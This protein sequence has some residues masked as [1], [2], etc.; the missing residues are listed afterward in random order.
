MFSALLPVNKYVITYELAHGRPYSAFEELLLKQIHE[1][2]PDGG[3]G[4]NQLRATFK[5]HNRLITEGLVTLIQEGWV[6]IVQHE[7]EM[8]YLV[9]EAGKITVE[10]GRRPENRHVRT[11]YATIARERL[12]GQLARANDLAL[13]TNREVQ[14]ATRRSVWSQ[15]LKPS[16]TRTAINGGEA[17]RLLYRSSE[18]QEWV[19]W[20]DSVVRVSQDAHYLPV[21]VDIS[22]SQ[23]I[24]LPD[25]WQ[26]LSPL[27]VAQVAER[28]VDDEEATRFHRELQELLRNRTARRASARQESEERP[29]E[30]GARRWERAEPFVAVSGPEV[31]VGATAMAG[32][33][34]ALEALNA[35]IGNVLIV[36]A[37]LTASRAKTAR[38]LLIGL[39]GRG[40]N[41]DF[42]WSAANAAEQD[43]EILSVLG[44]TRSNRPSGANVAAA[45]IMYNRT[46]CQATA[47]LML[48]ETLEGPVAVTGDVLLDELED[49]DGARL[50]PAARFAE[51]AALASLARLCAGWWEEL[52]ANEGALPAHRWKHL[53]ERWAGQAAASNVEDEQTDGVPLTA[54]D[55][56]IGPQRDAAQAEL[57]DSRSVTELMVSSKR[58]VAVGG[59]RMLVEVVEAGALGLSYCVTTSPVTQ[60]TD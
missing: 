6:A 33:R 38:D 4:L 34:L 25:R 14:N 60:K 47:D 18:N 26:H 12:T 49:S 32:S 11:A 16:I 56:F 48:V 57:R 35:A 10:S 45:T 29:G 46:P 42:L 15:A 52:P 23:V 22:R 50:S 31:A 17:E 2:T 20:I 27:I 37:G 24:G 44:A 8:R 43:K 3:C 54:V 59:D 39:R 55:L 58:R 53:A 5:V 30:A 41:A 13:V 28:M 36:T 40:V 19:R 7:Q 9:T 21:Q 51:P 1:M